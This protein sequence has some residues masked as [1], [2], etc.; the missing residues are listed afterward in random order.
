M[1]A[2]EYVDVF[3]TKERNVKGKKKNYTFSRLVLIWS[4]YSL[5]TRG[6]FPPRFRVAR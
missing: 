1:Q 6:S 5:V 4:I 3:N 2:W